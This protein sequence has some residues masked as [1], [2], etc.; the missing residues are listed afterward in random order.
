MCPPLAIKLVSELGSEKW[1]PL[2]AAGEKN[3][4]KR[5]TFG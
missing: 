4:Q 5:P 1:L 2:G 3:R